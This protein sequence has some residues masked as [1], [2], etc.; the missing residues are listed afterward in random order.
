MEA[1]FLK[2]YSVFNFLNVKIEAIVPFREKSSNIIVFTFLLR[3]MFKWCS[4]ELFLIVQEL[5]V[6]HFL[7][8]YIN[9]YWTF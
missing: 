9:F 7:S 6:R 4:K 1:M 3:A 5:T 2:D 8:R